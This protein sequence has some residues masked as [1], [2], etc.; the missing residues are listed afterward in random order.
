MYIGY[1]PY[2][3]KIGKFNTCGG[4]RNF[5]L[6]I[7]FCILASLQKRQ[8]MKP[9]LVMLVFAGY[10]AF[11][12][13]ISRITSRRADSASFFI[14]NRKSPWYVVAFGMIGASLSG[15]TFISVPGW[16]LS[17][18]F[19]YMQMVLGYLIGYLLI[20]LILLPVY[21]K[22]NLTS[23]YGY[24]DKRFGVFSYKTGSGFFL[25][26]R[27]MGASARLYIVALVLQ[28]TVFD[29]WKVPFAA[30]V[31][32]IIGLIFL[33]T[34]QGGIKT[35]IW[36]DTLQTFFM[37]TALVLTLFF[38]G[39][40]LGLSMG[41]LFSEV[42]G[43]EHGRVW[44]FEDFAGD[45]RHFIKYIIGGAFITLTMTGL[46]QDMMQ[47]NLSCKN[48]KDARKNM[49]WLGVALIPV[50]FLFLILGGALVLFVGKTGMAMPEA[51]D[52]LFPMVATQSGLP[53]I[54]GLVF[55]IGLIAAAFSSA[56]SALTSLTTSITVAIRGKEHAVESE[57]KKT[58]Y[59]VHFI[60]SLVLLA[61]I[62]LF[63]ALNNRSIIDTLFT[64][65]GYTY[66]PLLG[67]YAFGLFTKLD[68]RDKLV[69]FIAVVAP[70]VTYILQANSA[71]WFGGYTFSFEL[72][73]ING[74]LTFG[75]LWGTSRRI[76]P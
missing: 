25:I 24:L 70:V 11:L 75:M 28:Y 20:I 37:L 35:I 6:S 15:V 69:P 41:E 23:I 64:L 56:D 32:I 65:A 66:G 10:F 9:L 67:L 7:C 57:L 43:G 13:I 3:Y 27:V 59:K 53:A 74:L 50:N 39:K 5:F 52:S 4:N 17:S 72:L 36:T 44:F 1:D 55:L 60:L 12:L 21:Y 16:V 54:V 61:I 63:R 58:R 76:R 14:G 42:K 30:T 40:E 26:S 62:L 18:E 34:Y 31:L 49:F 51:A 2:R 71:R 33:Y 38:L 8:K 73:L 68:I 46:D 29:V 19:A 45:R 47:K 22:L 48:L